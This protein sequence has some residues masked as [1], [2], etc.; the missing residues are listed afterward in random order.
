[1][2]ESPWMDNVKEWAKDLAIALAVGLL[3]KA[4]VAD[5]RMVPTPSM[6]P[7]VQVGDRIFVE[8]VFVKWLGVERGDIIVFTP[9]VPS[10]DDYLKRVIGLPGETVEVNNGKVYINGEVLEEDYLAE[11]IRYK[12]G[13]V[14]VPEGKVLVLGDNRNYSEDSHRWGMLD[15]SAIHGRAW[16]RYWPFN[17]AGTLD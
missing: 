17:R 8:K 13:P 14:T 7:T 12:Y 11:T 9:P 16:L 3:L 5:A 4:S 2:K 6:V 10:T 1:E 15:Q